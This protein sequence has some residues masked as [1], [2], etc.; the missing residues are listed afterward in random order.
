MQTVQNLNWTDQ[1][2]A[3]VKSNLLEHEK[4]AL[5]EE[6]ASALHIS[7][8]QLQRNL[9]KEGTSFSD[10]VEQERR[11]RVHELLLQT[12]MTLEKIADTAGFL[13]YASFHRAFRRWTGTTPG[14]YRKSLRK[15]RDD[16]LEETA[17]RADLRDFSVVKDDP[18]SSPQIDS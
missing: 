18:K 7:Q 5:L 13:E 8:R 10:V 6:V 4:R 3:L 16:R 12:D 11:Q 2:A 14:Q 9:N 15:M 17:F 1:V